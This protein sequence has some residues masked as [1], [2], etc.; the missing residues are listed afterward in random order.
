MSHWLEQR[1]EQYLSFPFPLKDLSF[2]EANEYIFQESHKHNFIHGLMIIGPTD[3]PDQ[4]RETVHLNNLIWFPATI[5]TE[6]T[7]IFKN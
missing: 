7:W 4:V 1:V 6:S 5:P 3:D 2:A